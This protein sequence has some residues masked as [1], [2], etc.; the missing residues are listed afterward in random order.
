MNSAFE[1]IAFR[2]ISTAAAGNAVQPLYI[3]L[4]LKKSS[5]ATHQCKKDE[6]PSEAKTN[7][8]HDSISLLW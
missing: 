2:K 3:L 1:V 8:S 4:A 5:A 6:P 7:D